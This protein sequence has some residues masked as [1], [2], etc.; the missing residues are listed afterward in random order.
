MTPRT[1]HGPA[2]KTWGVVANEEE[3]EEE[4]DQEFI[5]AKSLSDAKAL[6][7]KEKMDQVDSFIWSAI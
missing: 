5:L 7:I 2:H 6:A 1:R 3:E 4:I